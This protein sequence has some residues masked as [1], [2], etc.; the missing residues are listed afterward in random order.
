MR[1]VRD[2]VADEDLL[3]LQPEQRLLDADVVDEVDV[4]LSP[5]LAGGDAL[6]LIAGSAPVVRR[7]ALA[8]LWHDPAD[9]LLLARYVRR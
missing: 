7:L 4:T 9:D 5:L 2:S 3:D 6:R 1:P 8:H